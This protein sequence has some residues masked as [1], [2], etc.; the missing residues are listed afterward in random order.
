MEVL[1]KAF[2]TA[3]GMPYGTVNLKNGVPPGETTETWYVFSKLALPFIQK[4]KL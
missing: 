2:D 4:Q 1:S 3:T